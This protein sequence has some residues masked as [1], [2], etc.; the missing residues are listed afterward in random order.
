MAHQKRITVVLDDHHFVLADLS[1][2]LGNADINIEAMDADSVKNHGIIHLVVDRYDEAL[3]IL[4]EADYHAFADDAM[5]IRV[6]DRPGALAKV[7]VRFKEAAID[8][9]SL[10]LVKRE[11]GFC[12]VSIV[13]E[14]PDDARELVRPYLVA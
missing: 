6:E 3:R 2:L 13:S 5:V 11:D 9:R 1:A 10:R 12:F 8:I 14:S 7:A 4:R